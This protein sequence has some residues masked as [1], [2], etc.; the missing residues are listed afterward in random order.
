MKQTG[1]FYGSSS[2]KT[3]SVAERM[4]MEL[5]GDI[6]I[7]DVAEAG[8]TGMMGFRNLILGVPTW[9][10][11]ALQEDWLTALPVLKGLDLRGRSVAIFGLGDQESYPDTFADAMGKLF[12]ALS[13]TGCR[14][15]GTWS[16]DGYVFE[17]S[18]ALRGRDFVGLVLDEENQA[19]MTLP[20]IREWLGELELN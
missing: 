6:G 11:G 10:L 3:A 12:D 4:N 17:G 2:G 16:A 20:R 19:G 15:T 14:F 5:G 8:L 1:I 9:G 13:G 18:K 7:C